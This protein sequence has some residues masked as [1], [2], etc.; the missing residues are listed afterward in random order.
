M[1]LKLKQVHSPRMLSAR[2]IVLALGLAGAAAWITLDGWSDILR[3]GLV[4]EELSYVLLA[5][6]MIGW[7]VW[8]RWSAFQPRVASP[9][10]LGLGL[11]VCGCSVYWYGYL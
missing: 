10:W 1:L 11:L 2:D 8:C 6:V 3:L 9:G 7:L 4:N 5:P